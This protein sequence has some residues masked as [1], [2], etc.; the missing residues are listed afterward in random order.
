MYPFEQLDQIGKPGAIGGFNLPQSP[1]L[2]LG[3]SRLMPFLVSP[4]PGLSLLAPELFGELT[5]E[6]LLPLL[7]LTPELFQGPAGLFFPAGRGPQGPLE[8]FPFVPAPLELFFQLT[9][10]LVLGILLGKRSG[11]GILR[12]PRGAFEGHP[13]SHHLGKE[14]HR[15]QEALRAAV[16]RQPAP[17]L[18]PGR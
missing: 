5:P 16:S 1:V 3:V 11:E 8:L 14:A 6:L 15:P 9:D 12:D 17:P 18:R 10:L 7:P 4:G 13:H 2:S